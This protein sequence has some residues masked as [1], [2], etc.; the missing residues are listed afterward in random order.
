MGAGT[1][2]PQHLKGKVYFMNPADLPEVFT[3]IRFSIN[4]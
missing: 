3:P 4:I 2:A 1:A